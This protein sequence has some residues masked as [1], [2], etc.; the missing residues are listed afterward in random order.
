MA[1]RSKLTE[2]QWNEILERHLAGESI[3]SLAREYGVSEGAIRQKI[4]TQAE[5]IKSVAKQIVTVEKT[6]DSLPISTQVH[7]RNYADRLK[8]ISGHMVSAAEY[9][10]ATSHRL[11]QIA[12]TQ[13][14]KIDDVNPGASIETIRTISVLTKT[15]N[16]AASLAFNIAKVCADKNMDSQQATEELSG[17]ALKVELARR[18]LPVDILEE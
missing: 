12:N 9:G 3:R 14:E 8:V 18:G 16:E 6:L 11:A 7:V 4:T 1:R 5:K 2:K 10:A 15:A 13:T 17:E